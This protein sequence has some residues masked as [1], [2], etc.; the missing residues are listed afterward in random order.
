M[1]RDFILAKERIN[2]RQQDRFR[3]KQIL[4]K[5]EAATDLGFPELP[6]SAKNTTGEVQGGI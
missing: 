2:R 1:G 6:A 3:K 4:Q 5:D